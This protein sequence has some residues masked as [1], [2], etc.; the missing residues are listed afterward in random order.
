MNIYAHVVSH[1]WVEDWP[2]ASLYVVH[3][4]KRLERRPDVRAIC[5]LYR[6]VSGD[7]GP[8]VEQAMTGGWDGIYLDVCDWRSWE[9]AAFATRVI[10][11]AG[12]LP[13]LT[14]G[15]PFHS[16]AQYRR[17]ARAR[18]RAFEAGIAGFQLEKGR[19]G[20]SRILLRNQDKIVL[21]KASS[22]IAD[23]FRA[24]FEAHASPKHYLHHTVV[25]GGW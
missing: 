18:R 11:K 12:P 6:M 1:V 15:W 8:L 19:L 9:D 23:D 10:K 22:E 3:A 5:Y 14:N 7:P 2:K 24:E 25:G 4:S 13:V 17:D 21:A 16:S 20:D